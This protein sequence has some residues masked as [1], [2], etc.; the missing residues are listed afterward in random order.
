[1][2]QRRPWRIRPADDARRLHLAEFCFRLA[3]LVRVQAAGLGEHRAARRL[4][5]VEDFGGTVLTALWSSTLQNLRTRGADAVHHFVKIYCR[6][7][8]V[9]KERNL[10]VSNA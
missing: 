4:D 5:G 3:Q 10:P 9:P 7:R 1:M 6:N 2:Q 8:Y